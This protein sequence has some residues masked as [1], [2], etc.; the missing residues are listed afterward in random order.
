MIF[1][2]CVRVCRCVLIIIHLATGKTSG[3]ADT[4]QQPL[5]NSEAVR[6]CLTIPDAPRSSQLRFQ[7]QPPY[8][9]GP[10]KTLAR[11]S[12]GNVLLHLMA[13]I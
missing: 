6:R 1:T 7:P 9:A 3:T 10:A 4:M 5:T 8:A 12:S 11:P 2:V 13:Y